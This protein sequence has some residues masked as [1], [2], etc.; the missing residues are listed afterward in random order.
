MAQQ[1]VVLVTGA[2][3][4]IGMAIVKELAA[5]EMR[6]FA[7]MRDVT[8]RNAGAVTE[9]GAYPN[10]TA[11]DLDVT[12]DASVIAAVAQVLREAGHIDVLINCAGITGTGVA[13]AFSV[14]Q[15]E[16]ILQ[17]N[18]VG[19]FRLMKAVLPGM[20]ARRDGLIVSIS[21]IGGR[22][23]IPGSGLYCASKFGIEALA[24]AVGYEASIHGVDWAV[25]QPGPFGTN[26]AVSS[27]NAA[28]QAVEA[29][30]GVTAA[31]FRRRMTEATIAALSTSG[32]STDPRDV[33]K[34]ISVLIRLPKGKRP[35]RQAIGLD[36][37]TNAMNADIAGHQRRFIEAI[38]MNDL[39]P[40]GG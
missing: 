29:D 5:D 19:P 10:L 14:A 26:L 8:G 3:S 17:T 4:G 36:H 25:I 16:T 28:D 30:Y 40:A 11:V 24:E 20:R 35:K 39:E 2:S 1:T 6:V 12:S 31:E 21:S 15:F 37:G 23:V 38:D 7:G 34:A 9:L 27:L 13:E 33:A 32:C 22:N 18:L